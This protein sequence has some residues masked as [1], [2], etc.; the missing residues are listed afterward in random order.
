MKKILLALLVIGQI[1]HAQ[2]QKTKDTTKTEELETVFVTANRTATLRKATPVA[3]SKITAKIIN[4]TKA[5]SAYEI[6][7]KAPGVLMV[8]LGNEQHM[9]S[10][11]QPMTTNAYYLYLEDGLPI[12]PMGI[13]NHNALLEINQFNLQNI[14]VV[15]GPVSSLYGPEAVGGTINLISIHPPVTPEFKLGIQ[16]DQWGYKRLQAAGGATV[17]KVGFH[18]AGISSLQE[19]GW[20]TYSDYKK[21]N[22]NIRVDYN[23]NDKTRLISNTIPT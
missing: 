6:I 5:T 10:I 7:N 8:N 13:F 23:I 16:T 17:G 4:E 19:N 12:R 14:E 2:D 1:A 22:L 3:I 21:D 11:R 15:K 18:I 20:M 9:M